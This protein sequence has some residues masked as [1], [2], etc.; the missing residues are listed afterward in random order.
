MPK[1]KC[2]RCGKWTNTALCDWVDCIETGMASKCYA[3]WDEENKCWVDG[4]ATNDKDADDF[5]ISFAK[6]II[7][8]QGKNDV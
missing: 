6:K 4:C 3:S 5:S 2:G 8:N 7:K 1:I